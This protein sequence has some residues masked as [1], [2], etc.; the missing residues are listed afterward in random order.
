MRILCCGNLMLK[1]AHCECHKVCS[2]LP[3]AI[4]E[5]HTVS[6]FEQLPQLGKMD[7]APHLLD[8][9]RTR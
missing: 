1:N 4:S 5:A 3:V 8:R 9:A 2:S 7:Q 6:S